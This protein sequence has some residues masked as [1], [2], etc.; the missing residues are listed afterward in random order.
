MVPM[1]KSA[2]MT[3]VYGWRMRG[4]WIMHMRKKKPIGK[5]E[6]VGFIRGP[7]KCLKTQREVMTHT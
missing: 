1:N 3:R 4:P 2:G 6:L 5:G 7:E